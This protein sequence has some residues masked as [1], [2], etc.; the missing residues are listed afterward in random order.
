[1]Q[2]RG[3]WASYAGGPP[4]P[5]ASSFLIMAMQH[6]LFPIAPNQMPCA[7]GSAL[8][9]WHWGSGE[10][11]SLYFRENNGEQF[12]VGLYGNGNRELPQQALRL[13]AWGSEEWVTWLR[14]EVSLS[15]MLGKGSSLMGWCPSGR[16]LAEG[17]WEQES[18]VFSE[19]LA[20]RMLELQHPIAY[21]LLFWENSLCPLFLSKQDHN[22]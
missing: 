19:A 17:K 8:V 18:F 6:M 20:W 7:E 11:I 3:G 1:M 16:S 14:W 10:G 15:L 5:E 22:K 21:L 12:S 2:A 9:P 4:V 13:P